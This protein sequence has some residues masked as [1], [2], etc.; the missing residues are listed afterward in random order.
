MVLTRS[1]RK[2]LSSITRRL[3]NELLIEIID[4]VPESDLASLCRVSKLLHALTLPFLNH[5]IVLVVYYG[6]PFI[7]FCSALVANPTRGS[8][9]RALTIRPRSTVS[10]RELDLLVEAMKLMSRLEELHLSVAALCPKLSLLTF[11]RLLTC[12]FRFLPSCHDVVQFLTRH[13][14]ITHLTA[15]LGVAYSS[16][17]IPTISLPGLVH[18]EASSHIFKLVVSPSL[19]AMRLFWSHPADIHHANFVDQTVLAFKALTNGDAPFISYQH[20]V[21]M[22]GVGCCAILDSLSRHMQYTTSLC[23]RVDSIDYVNYIAQIIPRFSKLEYLALECHYGLPV[24]R[25]KMEA[26]WLLVRDRVDGG[27]IGSLKACRIDHTA[28]KREGGLWVEY[29]KD[30]FQVQAGLSAFA[31]SAF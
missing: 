11:P 5:A 8:A 17:D 2:A 14:T 16:T 26:A 28:K 7:T 12:E 30:E 20:L 15:R 25:A 18:L 6:A 4:N 23:L 19:P 29:P 9:L 1:Q 21:N 31:A 24:T 13:A 3:P 22:C 27:T 10:D